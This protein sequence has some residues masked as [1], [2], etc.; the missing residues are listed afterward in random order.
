MCHFYEMNY[1]IGETL[2]VTVYLPD[3]HGVHDPI[4]R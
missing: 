2:T 4:D 3:D 1:P